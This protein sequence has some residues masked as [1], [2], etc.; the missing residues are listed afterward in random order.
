MIELADA[1][2]IFYDFEKFLNRPFRYH[3]EDWKEFAIFLYKRITSN[4]FTSKNIA[5]GLD[6]S[7]EEIQELLI[8]YPNLNPIFFKKNTG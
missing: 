7:V 6:Y 1:T 2:S 8:N 4:G 3:E 5:Y